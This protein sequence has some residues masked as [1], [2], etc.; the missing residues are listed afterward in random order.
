MRAIWRDAL[1]RSTAPQVAS[2]IAAIAAKRAITAAWFDAV[3]RVRRHRYDLDNPDGPS[4]ESI[5]IR[6]AHDA[7]RRFASL[8]PKNW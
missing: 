2:L 4:T 3:N 1:G 5:P 6:E 8:I 7:L